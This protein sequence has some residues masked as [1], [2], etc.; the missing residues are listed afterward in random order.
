MNAAAPPTQRQLFTLF[1]PLALSGIFFPLAAPVVNAALARTADPALALA[2]FA[3]GRGLS[4][5]LVSPLF[6]LRQ[7]TTALAK[8]RQ[9]LGVIHRWSAILGIGATSLLLIPTIPYF[10]EALVPGLMGIPADIARM[11]HPVLF[12]LAFSPLLV[13]GRGYY[14]GTLVRYGRTGPIGTGALLYLVGTAALLALGMAFDLLD[15]ALLAAVALFGGQLLYM[16]AVWPPYRRVVATQ[17]PKHDPEVAPHQRSGRYLMGFYWP[18]ALATVILSLSEPLLQAGMARLP[19]AELALAAYPVCTSLSWLAG[20]P[21]WN[22]QQL[23]IAQI[24]DRAS[25]VA[26]RRFVLTASLVLTGAMV[27]MAVPPFA[28][29]IFGYLMGLEGAIMD[30]A[31]DGFRILVPMPL[32]MG[33][34]SLYHGVL[35]SQDATRL[36]RTGAL[37][38]LAALIAVLAAGVVDGRVHGLFVAL[39]ATQISAAAELAYLHVKSKEFAVANPP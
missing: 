11:A 23:A 31:I 16:A 26:V 24:T 20:V 30:M 1:L 14:Q 35:I 22:I 6:S 25:F 8:D 19:L 17:V 29:W 33:G 36:A 12:V 13:V 18:L 21:L 7:V 3:V 2:A 4:N 5:A 15:G 38:R 27:L 9:T 32:L 34:R 10:Y 37:V 39:V 28:G